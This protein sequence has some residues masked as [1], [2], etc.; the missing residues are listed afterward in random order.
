MSSSNRRRARSL[1]PRRLDT[2]RPSRR[3]H[4]SE[5]PPR[6]QWQAPDRNGKRTFDEAF[7]D[8]DDNEWIFHPDLTTF[9]W[10]LQSPSIGL[11]SDRPSSSQE[12][13]MFGG[14][15]TP[16]LDFQ[17]RPIG[18]RRNWRKVLNKQR[19]QGESNSIGMPRPVTTSG[20]G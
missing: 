14:G 12:G 1:S 20:V 6:K 17:L 18:A 3:R 10:S 5:S 7:D 19:F 8:D 9:L 16:L 4:R 2:P 15:G 11:S 13:I